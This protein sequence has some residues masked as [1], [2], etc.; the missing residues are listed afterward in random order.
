MNWK[1]CRTIFYIFPVLVLLFYSVGFAAQPV[2]TRVS[3]D[4]N[5]NGG[6]N[7][8]Y[9]PVLS[10]DGRYTAFASNASNLVAGDQNN[11]SD[12]FV[13][14]RQSGQITRVSVD[15]SGN[16]GGSDQWNRGSESPSISADGRYVAFSSARNNLV[17][18]D[19][20]ST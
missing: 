19:S 6:N 3:F 4:V 20:N 12:V 11:C 9:S 16:E 10:A 5:G 7:W 1:Q 15:S 17:A 13:H 14:E 18:N 8:S 2:T